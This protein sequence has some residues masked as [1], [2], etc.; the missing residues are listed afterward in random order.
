MGIPYSTWSGAGGVRHPVYLGIREDKSAR[1]V[2][3]AVADPEAPR[4]AFSPRAA[5]AG[6]GARPQE[7]ERCGPAQKRAYEHWSDHAGRRCR[8]NRHA[9]RGVLAM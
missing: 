4:K 3:R 1:E 9:G 6:A 8:Q 5:T 2:V 7:W